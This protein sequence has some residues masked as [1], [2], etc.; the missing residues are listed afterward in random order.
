MQRYYL[1]ARVERIIYMVYICSYVYIYIWLYTYRRVVDDNAAGKR[2]CKIIYEWKFCTVKYEVLLVCCKSGMLIC[3]IVFI[4]QVVETIHT[5]IVT[6]IWTIS[7]AK[8]LEDILSNKKNLFKKLKIRVMIIYSSLIRFLG[9]P[10]LLKRNAFVSPC[11][12]NCHS[13]LL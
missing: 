6:L 13:W 9:T 1:P 7:C 2:H 8:F 12:S 11:S 4:Y 3:K 10:V 5:D